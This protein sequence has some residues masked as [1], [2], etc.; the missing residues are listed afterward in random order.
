MLSRLGLRKWQEILGKRDKKVFVE[1]DYVWAILRMKYMGVGAVRYSF[2]IG[3]KLLYTLSFLINIISPS[4]R[5]VQHAS[6]TNIPHGLAY[7][8][9]L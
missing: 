1:S 6:L 4:I 8:P 5:G 7:L 9:D 3:G 2:L